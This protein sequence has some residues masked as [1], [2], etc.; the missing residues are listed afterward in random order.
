MNTE[1]FMKE[2]GV[3]STDQLTMQQL[4]G[5][6]MRANDSGHKRGKN[7]KYNED[8]RAVETPNMNYDLYTL[9]KD[10]NQK[11]TAEISPIVARLVPSLP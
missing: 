5:I 9:A 8:L 2:M 7:Q 11:N 10:S 1:Q 4:D 3:M 6:Q